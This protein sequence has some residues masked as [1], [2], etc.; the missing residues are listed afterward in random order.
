MKHRLVAVVLVCAL[1]GTAGSVR[2]TESEAAAACDGM[3]YATQAGVRIAYSV[4]GAS[5]GSP[6][7]LVPGSGQHA[8]DWPAA[9]IAGLRQRGFRIVRLDP[10]DVGCS[11][12]LADKGVVDWP[13]LFGQLSAGAT[14]ETAYTVDDMAK[15]VL[16]V[17]DAEKIPRAHLVGVSAGA[18]VAGWLAAQ[19]P[20]RVDAVALLMANSGNPKN[21]IPADAARM[22]SAGAPPAPGASPAARRTFLAAMNDALEAGHPTRTTDELQAWLDSASARPLDADGMARTGA[23]LL[24]AGDLRERF[25]AIKARTL[26]LHGENDPLIPAAAGREVAES[27]PG[28][29]FLLQ[30]N[31]GHMLNSA[32]AQTVIEHLA[33]K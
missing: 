33:A 4:E 32:A 25:S 6:V 19:R 29:R 27:I 11:T 30:P 26:V 5:S 21:T 24:A 16:A 23:A 20:D 1:L 12:H 17:M 10:R 2:G 18:T 8:G 15:D 9:F 31:M 13:R 28:A 22:A 14:P 3:R 7:V